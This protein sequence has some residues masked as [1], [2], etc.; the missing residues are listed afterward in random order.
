MMPLEK[1]DLLEK[2]VTQMIEL[3]KKLQSDKRGLEEE[4]NQ[5][6]SQLQTMSLELELSHDKINSLAQTKEENERFQT[7]RGQ[8]YAKLETMLRGLEEIVI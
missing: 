2:Q 4:I 1:L 8:V 5:L 7:E 6:N 3:V